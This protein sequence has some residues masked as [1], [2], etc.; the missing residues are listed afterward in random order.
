MLKQ[1][2]ISCRPNQR[3]AARTY[4]VRLPSFKFQTWPPR[5]SSPSGNRCLPH[6]TS[7]TVIVRSRAMV[8]GCSPTFMRSRGTGID[9]RP[10]ACLLNSAAPPGYKTLIV[11]NAARLSCM[12]APR[13]SSG[14]RSISAGLHRAS[15]LPPPLRPAP[16]LSKILC[17]RRICEKRTSMS[18]HH[19][20]VTHPGRRGHLCPK[21]PQNLAAHS[22][23]V[24]PSSCTFATG[25][26]TMDMHGRPAALP[27]HN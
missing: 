6:I 2:I 21:R 20:E 9:A 26:A 15:R 23:S 7:Y 24:R 5:G 27:A 10:P 25:L 1:R 13:A 16:V 14:S 17:S 22:C 8:G 3:H 19:S 12:P 18:D 4:T 11:C